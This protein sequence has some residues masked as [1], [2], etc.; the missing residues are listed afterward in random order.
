MSPERTGDMDNKSRLY[1]YKDVSGDIVVEV[2]QYEEGVIRR[3]SVEFTTILRGGGQSPRTFDS[4]IKLME[5]MDEDNQKG[6]LATLPTILEHLSPEEGETRL[7]YP[8]GP[9][10]PSDP[11]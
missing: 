1:V 3:A 2:F 10:F 5:A 6:R 11:E 8:I 4:L 9:T 7:K